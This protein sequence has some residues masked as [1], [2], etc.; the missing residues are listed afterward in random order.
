MVEV[1]WLL[2]VLLVAGV[3]VELSLTISVQEIMDRLERLEKVGVVV[4]VAITQGV[5]VVRVEQRLVAVVV[6]EQPAH[7]ALAVQAA[8]AATA[9]SVFILGKGLI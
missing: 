5:M 2:M 9:L 8:Q 1:R 6:V 3:R 4:A 7:L